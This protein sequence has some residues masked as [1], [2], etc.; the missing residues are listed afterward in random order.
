MNKNQSA[1]IKRHGK[2]DRVLTDFTAAIAALPG[3]AA[4]VGAYRTLAAPLL[5]ITQ[6]QRPTSQGATQSKT[7]TETGLIAYLVRAA[8]AVYLVLRGIG[9]PEAL[10][11]AGALHRRRS[12]YTGFDDAELATEAA[13]V[14][15]LA[16]T[17]AA[18]IAPFNFTAAD[19]AELTRL[20]GSNTTQAPAPKLEIEKRKIGGQTLKTVLKSVDDFLK[21]SL[22]SAI[23]LVET[24][25]P[26]LYK[27]FHEAR[28]VDDPAY[29]T[30]KAKRALGKGTAPNPEGGR[31]GNG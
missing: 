22:R 3:I 31:V 6:Q 7:T 10:T 24:T 17:H 28:R 13:T 18:A 26:D 15:G 25:H 23:D 9:T 12:D 29:H 21:D 4:I 19:L 20:A 11:T 16:T 30:R 5:P 1:R 14:L 2:V 27:R 8:S